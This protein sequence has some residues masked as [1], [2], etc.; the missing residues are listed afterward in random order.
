[1]CVCVVLCCV[2]V[3]INR[4]SQ[5]LLFTS[6]HATQMCRHPC[7]LSNLK[8]LGK[9]TQDCVVISLATQSEVVFPSMCT[10][11]NLYHTQPYVVFTNMCTLSSLS[12]PLSSLYH[13][14]AIPVPATT[15]SQFLCFETQA[16]LLRDH[17]PVGRFISK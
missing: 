12:T 2:C 14:Q 4:S 1:M 5:L 13:T 3:Y 9:T 10:L 8:V 6:I 16:H 15:L 11:S 7:T 17:T